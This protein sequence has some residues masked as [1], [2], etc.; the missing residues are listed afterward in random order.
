MTYRTTLTRKGQMTMPASFRKKLGIKPGE[1]LIVEM[2]G[3]SVVVKK[4][5]WQKG[6]S[7]LHKKIAAHMKAHNLKPLSDSQLR[8]A[9]EQAWLDAAA[10]RV[11]RMKEI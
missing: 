7:E 4:N 8:K 9:R 6:L 10:H 1:Q 2:R 11:K 5:D 3:S